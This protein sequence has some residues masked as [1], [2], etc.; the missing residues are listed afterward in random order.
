MKKARTLPGKPKSSAKVH[1]FL[2]SVKLASKLK[3]NGTQ[4]AKGA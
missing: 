2:E 3:G 1:K 4:H